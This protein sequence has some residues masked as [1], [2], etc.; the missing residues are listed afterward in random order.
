MCQFPRLVHF[1]PVSKLEKR[2]SSH[3]TI[4]Q[5]PA[6]EEEFTFNNKEELMRTNQVLVKRYDS[7]LEQVMKIQQAL[8]QISGLITRFSENIQQ[9]DV[10]IEKSKYFSIFSRKIYE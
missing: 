8:G 7:D 5:N 10:I 3:H 1:S 9:Q 6:V 2:K 4:P